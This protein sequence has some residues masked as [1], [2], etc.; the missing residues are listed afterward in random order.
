VSIALAGCGSS[1][2]PA[3]SDE[4]ATAPPKIAEA[5][6]AIVATCA[7]CE[8]V[9]EIRRRGK[10]YWEPISTG[11]TFR[12][13]DWIRTGVNGGAKVR[14]V[15]GGHLELDPSSTL[16][17]E[18]D[19][20]KRGVHVALQAGAARGSHDG[21]HDAPIALRTADGEVH[22][23]GAGSSDFRI[24]STQNGSVDL[25][26]SRGKLVVRSDAGETNLEPAPPVEPVAAAATAPP[27]KPEPSTRPRPIV[28]AKPARIGFPQSIAPKIDARFRCL[29]LI[30]VA[31]KWSAVPGATSYKVMVARDLSF[32]SVVTTRDV[33]T[34]S[35]TF[36]PPG[37][38]TYVWRVAARDARGYGEYGF[39]RRMFCDR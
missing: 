16:F 35:F 38:G 1:S 8:G 29:M 4:P 32:S 36:N 19:G 7:Q 39:A 31:L 10:A 3:A 9:V 6:S 13:G 12:D 30:D 14:F 20:A 21:D 2:S 5:L 26:V 25:S 28:R 24:S 33:K 15:S 27:L 37:P 34:T 11:G 17:V 23:T 18:A 22:I